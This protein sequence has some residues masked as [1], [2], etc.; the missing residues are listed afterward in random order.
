MIQNRGKT[1]FKKSI[2]PTTIPK[3]RPTPKFGTPYTLP[4]ATTDQLGGVKVGDYLDMPR[5]HLSG[6]T[7]YDTIAASVAVKSEPRLVW[8]YAGETPNQIKQYSYQIPDNVDY[9]HITV[10][11]TQSTRTTLPAVAR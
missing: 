1:A 7:L 9:L 4:P 2:F 8:N 3:P 11:P 10:V 6:K 5:T